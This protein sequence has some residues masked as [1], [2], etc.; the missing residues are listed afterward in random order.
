MTNIGKRPT[1][2]K[3]LGAAVCISGIAGVAVSVQAMAQEVSDVL[4][5]TTKRPTHYAVAPE[6]GTLPEKVLRARIPYVSATSSGA[7]YDIDG[8]KVNGGLSANIVATGLALEY[9]INDELSF[10]LLIPYVTKNDLGMDADKFKNQRG[11]FTSKRNFYEAASALMIKQGICTNNDSCFALIDTGY[12]F[13]YDLSVQL[14]SGEPLTVPAGV[15]LNQGVHHLIA[16]SAKPESGATG[17][18][19][20]DLGVK[21]RWFKNDTMGHAVGLVLHTPTGKYEDVT[22]SQRA[23]GRGIM[24]IA[25]RSNFDYQIN[26]DFIAGWQHSIDYAVGK[27]KIKRSKLL[28]STQL[29]DVDAT[30][31]EGSFADGFANSNEFERPG[32]RSSGFVDVK[33]SFA[34]FSPMLASMGGKFRYGYDFDTAVRVEEMED[35]VSNGFRG[36]TERSRQQTLGLG[37]VFDGFQLESRVP[38]R[39][40]WDIDAPVAGANKAVAAVRNAVVTEL[41]YKF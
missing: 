11:Y 33:T 40:T 16:N 24:E 28:D 5:T 37:L 31:A 27:G 20:I 4:P 34:R 6:S 8:T 32:I 13:P 22:L 17:M 10:G 26:S 30:A 7:A 18:G 9:G 23:T 2:W 41:Y 35:A 21:Y 36:A 38:V 14:T 29:S 1:S 12:S 19:D 15:P 25:L 39:V 3:Q